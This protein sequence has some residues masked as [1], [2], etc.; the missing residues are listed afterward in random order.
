MKS[1]ARRAGLAALALALVGSLPTL[2]RAQARYPGWDLAPY[3]QAM[4]A[5]A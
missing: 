1:T 3:R 4:A 5:A 2:A